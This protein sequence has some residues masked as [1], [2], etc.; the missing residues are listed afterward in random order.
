MKGPQKQFNKAHVLRTLLIIEREGTIGRKELANKL[1][2]GEGTVRGIL[3]TLIEKGYLKSAVAIG[4][5]LTNKGKGFLIKLHNSILGPKIV[6]GKE[7]TIG[8]K[9]MAVLVRNATN[10]VEVGIKERDAAIKIGSLGASVLIFEKDELRFPVEPE[11]KIK[12]DALY[13]LFDF[14]EEDVLIIG[15][16]STYDK[17][18]NATIA[19]LLA[20]VDNRIV[21]S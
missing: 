11:L 14:R 16:D 12:D 19:A 18:E 17:A 20:L 10:K 3:K 1:I 9:D 2:I 8:A 6:D 4:H 5:K 15:T 7:L 21:I 13:G